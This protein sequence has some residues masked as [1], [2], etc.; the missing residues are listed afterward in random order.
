MGR[1]MLK[2][3]TLFF[4]LFADYRTCQEDDIKC[5][6]GLCVPSEK[7]CDGY[8]DC[9]DKKDEEGCEGTSCDLS[10]F[11]CAN[12]EKC[13]AEFQKCNHRKECTDGSDESDCSKLKIIPRSIHCMCIAMTDLGLAA[14]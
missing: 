8:F 9:R 13:I 10:E 1:E 2:I 12:G 5:G 11:R 6:N 3:C 14:Q 4:S 7:S